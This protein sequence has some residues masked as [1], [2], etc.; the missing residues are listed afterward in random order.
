MTERTQVSFVVPTLNR[1]RYVVRAVDSCLATSA[2]HPDVDVEVIVLDS[3]SDD[4]S[5]EELEQRFVHDPRVVLARNARGLGPTHSWLDGAR[6]VT[7]DLVTFLWSD[8][9]VS[10]DFLTV[11][12]PALRAGCSMAMGEGV[13]RDIDNEDGL[14]ASGAAQGVTITG[15]A[16]LRRHLGLV[17]GPALPVSP[18]V[19]LFTR[20]VFDRWMHAVETWCTQP[21]IRHTI[22]WRRAIGPDLMLFLMSALDEAGGTNGSRVRIEPIVVAQFSSHAQSITISSSTWP[23]RA[24]YWLAKRWAVERLGVQQTAQDG[25]ARLAILGLALARNAR[26][27]DPGP[28]ITPDL[29][30]SFAAQVAQTRAQ[31]FAAAGPVRGI[32]ALATS[33]VRLA[34]RVA[35]R[36]PSGNGAG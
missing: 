7:G 35:S 20:A 18:A 16:F 17:P 34:W 28:G 14:P 26:H 1:G 24:G 15:D 23:L 11:L 4:G 29:R 2:G 3:M 25:A 33:A 19:A 22:M 9:Y 13:V 8:D 31:L 36:S 30:D 6:L 5:W 10:P 27:A 12:L 32:G 21:G